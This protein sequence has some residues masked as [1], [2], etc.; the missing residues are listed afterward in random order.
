MPECGK[1]VLVGAGPGDPGL[2]TLAGRQWVERAEVLV[3]DR[4]VARELVAM[5]PAGCERVYVGK[6]PERHTLSQDEINALLLEHARAG[7]LVV[8]L[9]GGDPFVFGRGG[10]EALALRAADVP[11]AVVPGV[12]AAVASPAYAGIPVTHR[13]M[14]STFTVVTGHEAPDKLASAVD[15]EGLA[16]IGGT[17][18]F[19]MGMRNI[20]LICENLMRC[21]MGAA[22]PAAVVERG[23]WPGQRVVASTLGA[24]GA[25]VAASGL[26]SPATIVVGEVARLHAELAW[27]ATRPLAGKHVVVTRARCQASKLSRQLEQLGATVEE[28]PLIR[29]EPTGVTELVRCALDELPS[30]DHVVFCSVNGVRY[31]AEALAAH[32]GARDLSALT[33]RAVA[34]GPATAEA[35]AARGA[36]GVIV[37]EEGSAEGLLSLLEHMTRPGERVLVV[38]A[39][40][41]R[42]VIQDGLAPRGVIVAEAPVYRNVPDESS[43]EALVSAL[44]AG[45][46]DAIMLTSS[47]TARNLRDAL[48]GELGLLEG[49]KLLSIGPVTTQTVRELDMACAAEADEPTVSALA[50]LAERE[51]GGV[52]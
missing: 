33:A 23:T 13:G 10:E 39:E 41:A 18:I 26:A 15:W 44:R 30:F 9:K 35:L 40:H 11:Y 43:R 45:R 51:L 46:V 7:K 5:A 4:L 20:N 3:Y 25:D 36:E 34:V 47:S 21:G 50:R 14:S 2:M 49:V 22:T 37:P 16:R 8:R 31:F 1:V 6:T 28:R 24:L 19:L 42:S 48:E 32:A 17:L 38:R 52:S 12:T 29:L 27:R